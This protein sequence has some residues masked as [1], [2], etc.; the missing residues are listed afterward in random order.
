V[1]SP[2]PIAA[3]ESIHRDIEGLDRRN[4]RTVAGRAS[5]LLFAVAARLV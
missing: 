5:R 2:R 4:A 1:R 3:L